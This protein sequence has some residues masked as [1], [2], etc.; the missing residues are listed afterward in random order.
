MDL[1]GVGDGEG[2]IGASDG[3]ESARTVPVV[4]LRDR[5]GGEDEKG[6]Q[7]KEGYAFHNDEG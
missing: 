6:K 3:V 7:E 5:A 2:L 1:L 4:V